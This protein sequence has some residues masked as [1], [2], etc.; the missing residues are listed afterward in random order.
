MMHF[1]VVIPARY[2]SSRFPGKLLSTIRGR[3]ILSHVVDL[4]KQSG[5]E[6]IVVATDDRRIAEALETSGC[7]VIMTSLT[8]ISGTDRIAEVAAIKKWPPE[9]LVVNVQGDEP[10]IPPALIN[11][12]AQTLW[13]TPNA[14]AS[15]A[16]FPIF[17]KEELFNPNL[18]KVVLNHENHALYFSRAPIP[19]SRDTF[20]DGSTNMPDNYSGFGHI[21]IY[22]YRAKF[23]SKYSDLPFSSLETFEKLE[24]LRML[25]AAH[26][27]VVTHTE[28][29]PA[30]GIDTPDDLERAR[31]LLSK[32]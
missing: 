25:Q 8:H 11:D 7:Q 12:V 27:I 15:T 23:L 22:G 3:T 31:E 6:E 14:S 26:R 10:F 19:W 20:A 17:E 2:G 32:L 13:D 29:P 16:C 24:Q 9:T 4:A 30:P 28:A 21:G 5:A 1:K 18:V